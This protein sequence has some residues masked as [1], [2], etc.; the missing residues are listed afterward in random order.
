MYTIRN[1]I[2]IWNTK[3]TFKS[4]LNS[5]ICH[6]F[7]FKAI[8]WILYALNWARV[9]QKNVSQFKPEFFSFFVFQILHFHT[10]QSNNLEVFIGIVLHYVRQ[11]IHSNNWTLYEYVCVFVM[12]L[13]S[14]CFCLRRIR[15]F[16]LVWLAQMFQCLSF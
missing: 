3:I 6:R 13:I 8:R 10:N 7:K 14:F 11:L 15:E 16:Y 9:F 1:E 2:K 4:V 12:C 5:Q